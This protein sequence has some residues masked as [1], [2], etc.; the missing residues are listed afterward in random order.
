MYSNTN[1]TLILIY[2]IEILFLYWLAHWARGANPGF[3]SWAGLGRAQRSPGL[4]RVGLALFG[5]GLAHWKACA[6]FEIFLPL[7]K[8]RVCEA[9][10]P[11]FGVKLGRV[12]PTFVVRIAHDETESF[13]I[14]LSLFTPKVITMPSVVSESESLDYAQIELLGANMTLLQVQ[15]F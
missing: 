4:G 3:L 5:P 11:I 13:V 2:N 14:L 10:M 15:Q 1:Y 8:P 9:K 6:D 12:P 7:T